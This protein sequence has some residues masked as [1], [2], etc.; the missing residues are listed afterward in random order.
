MST[1][2]INDTRIDRH[3]GC[4][5][6][7]S[8]IDLL[9][10]RNGLGPVQYWPAHLDLA[11]VPEFHEAL[12][13][14]R[15]VVING[16]GTIHHDRPAGRRILEVGKLARSADVPAALINTGWEANGSEF[17]E[18][19]QHF[20]LVSA[21][22]SCSASRMREG[23]ASVHIVPDLSF[24]YVR[25]HISSISPQTRSGIGFT[26]NVDRLKALTL[27]QI[28]RFCGGETISICYADPGVA[29]WMRFIRDGV[30]LWED[31]R[32]PLQL[33]SLLRLRHRLWQ[34]SCKD[35]HSFSERISELELLV[36]GRF[37]ACTFA[38]AT[39][40]PIIAHSSNTGK[41]EALFSDIGLEPWRC[42]QALGPTEVFDAGARYWSKIERAALDDYLEGA[43][44]AIELLFYDLAALASK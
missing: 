11:C 29:G 16:E 6:V 18:L 39:G 25:K 27:E 24:W 41:I 14:A 38:L 2:V 7:M 44:K 37:H 35:T 43:V 1:L 8:T 34:H 28:R 32:R 12:G 9:L 19:L 15:L 20:D 40:T 3:H 17:I 5:A 10:R 31:S 21:R 36:S 33:S 42:N 23:G 26:D 13:A 22:E 4:N 30:S